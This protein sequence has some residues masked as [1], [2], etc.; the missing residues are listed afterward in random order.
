MCVCLEFKFK[1]LK[2]LE[3]LFLSLYEDEV[4]RFSNV[5]RLESGEGRIK[6][7]IF[8]AGELQR[9]NGKRRGGG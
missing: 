6:N 2:R 8:G 4:K 1:W 5:E 3:S 9:D 7:E